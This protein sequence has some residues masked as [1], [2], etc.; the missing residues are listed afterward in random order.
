MNQAWEEIYASHYRRLV[1]LMTA[2]CGS[3]TD[4]EE[5]V[6]EAFA[7]GL[8]MSG[9]RPPPDDPQAWLYRVASNVVKARW[10][11]TKVAQRIWPRLAAGE[12][13][14]SPAEGTPRVAWRAASDFTTARTDDAGNWTTVTPNTVETVR[15]FAAVDGNTAILMDFVNVY[16]T[17]DAGRT[18]TTHPIAP[19]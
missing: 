14:V 13:V 5:A 12:P 11:R 9:R 18:W 8:G 4:A 1:T 6:Q 7:R 16:S 19:N 17:R 2:L 10:R 3:V 15:W